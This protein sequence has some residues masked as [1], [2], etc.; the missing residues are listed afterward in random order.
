MNPISLS[1]KVATDSAPRPGLTRDQFDVW[2]PKSKP[3]PI[4]EPREKLREEVRRE[5]TEIERGRVEEGK[6]KRKERENG[7]KRGEEETIR[8]E[9]RGEKG[10]RQGRRIREDERN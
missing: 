7:E 10:E 5:R 3:L 6:T 8:E 4:S 9:R 1:G 2:N